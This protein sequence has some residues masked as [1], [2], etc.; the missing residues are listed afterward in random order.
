MYRVEIDVT[1]VTQPARAGIDYS[2]LYCRN[3]SSRSIFILSNSEYVSSK[4]GE[5][6]LRKQD[7]DTAHYDYRFL[8]NSLI[9]LG[10]KN[11]SLKFGQSERSRADANI[12]RLKLAGIGQIVCNM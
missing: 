1:R 8:T 2:S 6:G 12:I 10:V 4:V 9:L 3:A 7:A 5:T 11:A